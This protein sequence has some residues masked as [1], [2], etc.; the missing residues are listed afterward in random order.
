MSP[1]AGTIVVNIVHIA[2]MPMLAQQKASLMT[3]TM[4]I[5]WKRS[6]LRLQQ[7]TDHAWILRLSHDKNTEFVCE[8]Y[9][10]LQ[11]FFGLKR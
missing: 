5:Q 10:T 9:I 7:V 4:K 3:M 1:M 8:T 2:T 6:H 11:S